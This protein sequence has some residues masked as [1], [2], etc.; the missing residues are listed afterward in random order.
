MAPYIDI[1]KD[2]LKK[3]CDVLKKLQSI[4]EFHHDLPNSDVPIPQNVLDSFLFKIS[5]DGNGFAFVNTASKQLL[6]NRL[7]PQVGVVYQKA[8][9]L[10]S[11]IYWVLP[12]DSPHRRYA[13]FNDRLTGINYIDLHDA[14]EVCMHAFPLLFPNGNLSVKQNP[15]IPRFSIFDKSPRAKM[16]GLLHH[17]PGIMSEFIHKS[18]TLLDRCVA[19]CWAIIEQNDLVFR[20]KNAYK[21]IPRAAIPEAVIKIPATVVGSKSYFKQKREDLYAIGSK[22]GVADLF[23]TVTA[24]QKAAD[25]PK[26]SSHFYQT[27]NYIAKHKLLVKYIKDSKCFGEVDVI[28]STQEFQQRGNCH[29]H[30]LIWLKK[31][32]PNR[33][34]ADNI[35][36]FISAS[37][38]QDKSDP[39]DR[40]FVGL[41]THNCS[42]YCLRTGLDGIPTCRFGYPME[43]CSSARLSASNRY[44]YARDEFSARCVPHSKFLSA[45]ADCHV[46]VDFC[47]NY[48]VLPYLSK[49]VTKGEEA[50]NA[51]K[52]PS[53]Q[54]ETANVKKN[55]ILDYLCGRWVST[56]AASMM[57]YNF[58][59]FYCSSTVH[60][61]IVH[62]DPNDAIN[63]D[64]VRDATVAVG[65]A[66]H[67]SFQ[68]S[69]R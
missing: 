20:S 52:I 24:N 47:S 40:K 29:S 39:A 49:Y 4:H 18:G 35:D 19:T 68:S 11:R 58:K 8:K 25:L 56:E 65:T 12:R 57:L 67:L 13:S 22:L 1:F 27:E 59:L 44:I 66:A 38:P 42:A 7:S 53:F 34:T 36:D 50:I 37:F 69:F 46:Y 32:D 41:Y 16:V 60:R 31:D 55:E 2:T 48:N 28:C 45:L 61:M 63:P 54:G 62:L 10:N 6:K 15:A 43:P 17:R 21:N 5:D 23:I 3:H 26:T 14:Y 9:A 33:I 64:A 51:S 30:I